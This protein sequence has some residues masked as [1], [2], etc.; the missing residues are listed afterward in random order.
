LEISAGA[1][2]QIETAIRQIERFEGRPLSVYDLD[3]DLLR[4]F[5]ADFRATHSPATTNSRRRDLL[6]LWQCA[7]D[8]SVIDRP[9]RRKKVR[10]A[11]DRPR[12]PEAWTPEQVAAILKASQA[13]VIPIGGLPAPAWWRS[14]ILTLYDTGGRLG[15]VLAVES[16]DL[17]VESRRVILRRTKTG[18]ERFALIHQDTAEAIRVIYDPSRLLV[19]PVH[20][21]RA[22]LDRRFR[23]ILARAGI[24]YR[25]GVLFRT[26]RR[27]SGTLV[28]AA[29]G[30]GAK[31][32]GNTRQVFERHYKDPRFF[33][34]D[35]ERLPRPT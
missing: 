8:E 10:R 20:F 31:H 18:R 6:A 4:R 7:F 15:E 13:D 16:A 24:P 25:P 26:F 33:G 30:D 5:L 29:G 21:T 14:L 19:W 32:L 34:S 3:E 9:P 12:I 23:R 35:L 22:G 1:I 2:R 17:D 28:E 27:T 11:K